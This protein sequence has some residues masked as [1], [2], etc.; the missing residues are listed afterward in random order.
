VTG[1]NNIIN[2]GK[3]DILTLTGANN[4]ILT[5]LNDTINLVN[6]AKIFVS[7]ANI[8]TFNGNNGTGTYIITG[9]NN[10]ITLDSNSYLTVGLGSMN[11][12]GKVNNT[13][14]FAAVSN[15]C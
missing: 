9:N 3:N 12:T 15:V 11:I 1:G 6:Y 5:S 4:T 10:N 2:L 13:I 7:D 8:T 14:S